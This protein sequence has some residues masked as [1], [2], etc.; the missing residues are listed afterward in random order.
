MKI[1]LV[2]SGDKKKS[3]NKRLQRVGEKKFRYVE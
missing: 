1:T 2:A 3:L